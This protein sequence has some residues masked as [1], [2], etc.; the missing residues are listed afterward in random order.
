M[1]DTCRNFRDLLTQGQAT[2]KDY[3]HVE[4]CQA[5]ELWLQ[6]HMNFRDLNLPLPE[7]LPGKLT[8]PPCDEFLKEIST[9]VTTRELEESAPPCP[10]CMQTLAAME[11]LDTVLSTPL[12][13]SQTLKRR[14]FRIARP[15][16]STVFQ[17]VQ[18]AAALLMA[19]VLTFLTS[20]IGKNR[21]DT[22]KTLLTSKV[23][24]EMSLA[25]AYLYKLYGQ[26]RG[27]LA[28]TLAQ[29]N[30]EQEENDEMPVSP[31]K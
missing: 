14:L 12:P 27:R 22:Q 28:Q 4:H 5:C 25:K 17:I 2:W 18:I 8:T 30:P 13:V 21:I 15:K 20:P 26:A 6:E 3:E 9:L 19:A 11:H 31:G 29:Y 16:T 23:N 24:V 1:T 10:S 7:D